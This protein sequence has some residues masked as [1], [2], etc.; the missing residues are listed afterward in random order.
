MVQGWHGSPM[1][2][3]HMYSSLHTYTYV[4]VY[5]E[6]KR[7]GFIIRNWLTNCEGWQVPW[8]AIYKLKIQKSWWVYLVQ[9]QRPENQENWWYKFQSEYR[10]PIFQLRNGQKLNSP[11]LLLFV[12]FRPPKDWMRLTYTGEDHRLYSICRF[13]G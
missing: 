3:T 4:C 8:F 11:L 5:S 9:P 13:K 6:R 7:L 10:R 1:N 12:L 2:Y